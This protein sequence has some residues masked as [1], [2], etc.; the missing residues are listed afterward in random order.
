MSSLTEVITPDSPEFLCVEIWVT[1]IGFVVQLNGHCICPSR[2]RGPIR[3]VCKKWNSIIVNHFYRKKSLLHCSGELTNIIREPYPAIAKSCLRFLN[4]GFRS[5]EILTRCGYPIL[6]K[7]PLL[8][9]KLEA[10]SMV[11]VSD[12][13]KD[14]TPQYPEFE[15]LPDIIAANRRL[16]NCI[17]K[18]NIN[19][20]CELYYGRR[21]YRE[22]CPP[23]FGSEQAVIDLPG[24]IYSKIDPS[25]S[26]YFICRMFLKFVAGEEFSG[27]ECVKFQFHM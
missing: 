16:I 13:P 9:A 23:I 18:I 6:I 7:T 4:Y 12:I 22:F 14:P 2:N 15:T 26:G 5:T 11:I 25:L 1:I 20:W 17:N 19:W 3:L 27:V 21:R 24:E 8:L 10:R